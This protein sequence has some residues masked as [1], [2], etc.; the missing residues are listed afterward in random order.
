MR[1]QLKEQCTKQSDCHHG[2]GYPSVVL[3]VMVG[4]SASGIA[5]SNLFARLVK[6]YRFP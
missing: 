5:L 6:H 1:E 4:V 2:N 3:C